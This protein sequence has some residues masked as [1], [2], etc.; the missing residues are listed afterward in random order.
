MSHLAW[1]GSLRDVNTSGINTPNVNDILIFNGTNWVPG[2]NNNGAGSTTFNIT[3]LGVNSFS[4][5]DA[6]TVD[7][8]RIAATDSWLDIDTVT[9][10]SVKLGWATSPTTGGSTRQVLAFNDTGDTYEWRQPVTIASGSSTY[11]GFDPDSWELSVKNLLITDVTVDA[12]ELSIGDYVS[13]NYTVGNEH[14]EGDIIILTNATGGS[15]TWIHNGGTAGTTADFTQILNA[16]AL[17]SFNIDGDTGTPQ[18]ILNGNTVSILGSNAINTIVGATDTIT[19]K[20]GGSLVENTTITGTSFDMLFTSTSGDFGVEQTTG[21]I[22]FTSTT[23]GVNL[24]SDLGVATPINFH[25]PTGAFITSFRAGAQSVDLNYTLPVIAPT[26][27]QVLTSTTGGIL[28]WEDASSELDIVD[29][30]GSS[31]STIDL[32]SQ[33]LVFSN[34]L[35]AATPRT[36]KLGGTLVENTTINTDTYNT[37]FS[38]TTGNFSIT[39]ST[40]QI[41]LTSSGAGPINVS[42]VGGGITLTETTGNISANLTTGDF[43]VATTGASGNISLTTTGSGSTITMTTDADGGDVTVGTLNNSADVVLEGQRVDMNGTRNTLIQTVAANYTAV[44]GVD[45]VILI[46]TNATSVVVTLPSAANSVAGDL[47]T[48][49]VVDLTNDA[50]VSPPT[51]E[52][53]D[54]YATNAN[55][56]YVNN[57]DSYT[58]V[59][60]DTNTQWLII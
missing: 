16:G 17:T 46:D 13:T 38:G 32:L 18:S 29:N 21:S 9:A 58:F 10:D 60:N 8:N 14:Q 31:V 48:V 40:G 43:I 22:N 39:R 28:S 36:A 5:S 3:G 45:S 12:V 52:A 1:I 27:G 53:I 47:Y 30:I 25:D 41:N 34:G 11:L 50:A 44:P 49:K 26:A 56:G 6:D 42:S 4:V 51:G 33:D 59:R 57:M 37:A 54:D 23:N 24:K 35:N 55:V 20:L 7:F 15:Q 2:P 19:V